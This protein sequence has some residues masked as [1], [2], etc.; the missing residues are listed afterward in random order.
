MMDGRRRSCRAT[1]E[2]STHRHDPV[3]ARV[4]LDAQTPHGAIGGA[5]KARQVAKIDVLTAEGI[6]TGPARR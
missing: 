2:T 3:C 6:G 4:L 5:F 1:A